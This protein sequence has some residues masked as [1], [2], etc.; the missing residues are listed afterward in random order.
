MVRLNIEQMPLATLRQYHAYLLL[1]C[2]DPITSAERQ[3]Y[4]EERRRVATRL[5]FL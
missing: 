2:A 5:A 3:A 4:R 1:I